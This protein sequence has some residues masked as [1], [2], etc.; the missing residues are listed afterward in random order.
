MRRGTLVIGQWIAFQIL[1]PPYKYSGM[2]WFGAH[3]ESSD[4]DL[5]GSF[6]FVLQYRWAIAA[7][8]VMHTRSTKFSMYSSI[9]VSTRPAAGKKKGVDI[10]L[11]NRGWHINTDFRVIGFSGVSSVTAVPGT[12]EVLVIQK[13]CSTCTTALDHRFILCDLIFCQIPSPSKLCCVIWYFF[14]Y[15]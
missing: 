11:K 5:D 9:V 3:R 2:F 1:I 15:P 10:F 12:A 6:T 4:H 14:K 7:R 13:Y 8:G